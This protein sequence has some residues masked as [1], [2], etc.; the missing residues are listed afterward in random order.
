MELV[1][2]VYANLAPSTSELYLSQSCFS[3]Q[4]SETER[5][6]KQKSKKKARVYLEFG[7]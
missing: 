5:T 2:L 1:A 7:F 3:H 6:L 4:G